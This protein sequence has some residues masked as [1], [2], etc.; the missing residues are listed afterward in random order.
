MLRLVIEE[1]ISL[2]SL[3]SKLNL[4][5][6]GSPKSPG[7]YRYLF[8]VEKVVSVFGC[9]WVD[10]LVVVLF[11]RSHIHVHSPTVSLFRWAA[12]IYIQSLIVLTGKD[13]S[14]RSVQLVTRHAFFV[15]DVDRAW[16][17]FWRPIHVNDSA[18]TGSRK[19][20]YQPVKLL[21]V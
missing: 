6:S 2:K 1:V 12:L 15:I 3:N 18:L 5:I 14:M 9:R 21:S 20:A 11:H 16:G 19:S 8:W 4:I 17:A 10:S 7:F 13:V